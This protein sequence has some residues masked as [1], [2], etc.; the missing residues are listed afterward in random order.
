MNKKGKRIEWIDAARGLAMWT[1][2][3]MHIMGYCM[4]VI[5][6]SPL[7]SFLTTYFIPGFF[8]ISG[9][10]TKLY[11]SFDHNLLRDSTWK[12]TLQLLI[13]TVVFIIIY[14]LTKDIAIKDMVFHP[15]KKGYWFTLC[16]YEMYIVFYCIVSICLMIKA[17]RKF[18][19]IL[20]AC[21]IIFTIAL[22]HYI[23][24]NVD[25]A[26]P[27]SPLWLKISGIVN[28]IDCLPYFLLGVILKEYDKYFKK[29]IGGY[30]GYKYITVAL[31]FCILMTYFT[32]IIPSKISAMIHVIVIFSVLYSLFENS[33]NIRCP[34][35]NKLLNA[36]TIIGNNTLEIYFLHYFMLF[37]PPLIISQ[38][39]NNVINATVEKC[40]VTI[41]ELL[42][43][44]S[45]AFLICY[46]CIVFSTIL[47]QIP[48]IGAICFGEKWSYQS[49]NVDRSLKI[50][51]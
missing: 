32:P 26:S 4:D 47:K 22:S 33:N 19:S 41:P 46:L 35:L 20:L 11:E 42:I 49:I 50:Q 8:V 10:V 17:N 23:N 37:T 18:Y 43:V 24:A 45:I 40:S 30:G 29:I 3:Y 44:G 31:F 9:Y 12:K 5:A 25:W 48:Y 7:Y 13:P 21:L 38:Y 39:L 51:Q 34:Y 36:F 14:A 27:T 2:V 16:L 28:L 1:V 6:Y 15:S